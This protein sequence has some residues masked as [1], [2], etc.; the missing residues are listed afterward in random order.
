MSYVQKPIA[1]TLFF[2]STLSAALSFQ[3]AQNQS[4]TGQNQQGSASST[5][6]PATEKVRITNINPPSADPPRKP[7]SDTAA[8]PQ[9][10]AI[11]PQG[12][13]EFQRFVY[14]T[15]GQTLPIFGQKLFRNAPATFAP[16]DRVPVTPEYVVGPGD[17]IVLRAWGQIDIDYHGFVDRGGN[18]F[19]P[20]VGD[21]SV[22]GVAFKD[23]Q[24]LLKN[25]IGHYYRGFELNVSLGQLR[26]IQVFV[27][28]QARTPGNYT[29]S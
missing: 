21:V 15:T 23:L 8:I 1:L 6:I 2:V 29:I 4:Q 14:L 10:D 7:A 16:V 11:E 24:P 26:S 19:V 5:R 17:E 9:K 22:S 18:L 25:A 28:G 3:D 20:T 13:S 27:T 12:F